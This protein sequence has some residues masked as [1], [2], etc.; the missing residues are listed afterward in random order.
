[1]PNLE[2]NQHHPVA[3]VAAK[4]ESHDPRGD[5]EMKMT[6]EESAAVPEDAGGAKDDNEPP[7]AD[8]EPDWDAI[9]RHEPARTDAPAFLAARDRRSD[10][11]DRFAAGL[12]ALHDSVT[13]S[14]G[15][16]VGV[17]TDLLDARAQKL[18]EYEQVLTHDYVANERTRA[19]MNRKLEESARIAQGL[20]ANLLMRV[21][22]PGDDGGDAAS[23]LGGAAGMRDSGNGDEDVK[24]NGVGGEGG[25]EEPDWD[26]ITKHDPAR[27]EVPIFLA[28]KSRRE[29]ACARFSSA[30]EEFQASVEGYVQDI[31]QTVADLY[32]SR[33]MKL[34]EYEQ[35]L[36]HDYVAN[37]K[38]RA[39]M[40]SSLEE[41]AT[42]A[43]AMFEELMKRVTQPGALQ[44][45]HP[46]APGVF[47]QAT[48][49]GDSP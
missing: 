2:N 46:P 22:Q 7:P 33:T 47:T 29:A 5:E 49:L 9:L 32:N 37:D 18:Y 14:A 19:S 43:H 20:F 6:T 15:G 4:E 35:V 40:Q 36:K 23:A 26:A 13:R 28:A 12:D 24:T 42:A 30:I 16:L 1:M 31:T 48:T 21:A 34:D 25:E 27:T 45:Q 3:T 39:K 41:S 8:D 17:V 38:M 11:N 10:A 44:Q